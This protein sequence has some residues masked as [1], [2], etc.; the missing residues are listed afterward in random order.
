VGLGTIFAAALYERALALETPRFNPRPLPLD[1]AGWGKIAGAVAEQHEKQ[2]ARLAAA[3]QRLQRGDT[4]AQLRARLQPMLPGAAWVKGV[5]EQA[6]AA[7]RVE[8]LGIDR[9]RFLW[10]VLNSAQIRERFT[11][12]DLGWA[13]GILPDA[14]AEI[15]DEYLG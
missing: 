2:S 8:D 9:E 12:I 11:S 1:R 15:V 3:C 13:T 7:H 14:A 5:L 6:G 4:W 10:A